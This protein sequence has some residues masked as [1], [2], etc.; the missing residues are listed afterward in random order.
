MSV[1]INLSVFSIAQNICIHISLGWKLNKRLI[2]DAHAYLCVCLKGSPY[3]GSTSY[4]AKLCREKMK[5]ES[6]K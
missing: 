6:L 1:L 3:K 2:T 4:Q 5:P